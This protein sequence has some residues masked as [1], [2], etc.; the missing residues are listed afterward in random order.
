M[1]KMPLLASIPPGYIPYDEALQIAGKR[2]VNLVS[3]GK[4]E[5]VRIRRRRQTPLKAFRREDIERLNEPPAIPSGYLTKPEAMK[6]LGRSLKIFEALIK[7]HNVQPIFVPMQGRRPAPTYAEADIR[8]I[9]RPVTAVEQQAKPQPQSQTA[10]LIDAITR[11]IPAPADT[12]VPAHCKQLLTM[13]EAHA[14]G[15]PVSLLREL[16]SREHPP[17]V[18][19]GKRGFRFSASAL[20]IASNIVSIHAPITGATQITI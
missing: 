20:Q 2:L 5:Y 13:A 10:A 15:W 7:K 6:L 1:T 16:K 11:L 9:M 12:S 14:L 17:G 8:A 3:R 4:I 19:Y 18:R